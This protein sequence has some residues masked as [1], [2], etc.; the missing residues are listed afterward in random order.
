RILLLVNYDVDGVCA[1]K[2]LQTLFRC[3]NTLY[4]LVP[5]QGTQ[6]LVESYFKHVEQIKI[7]LMVNC[8]GNIDIVETLQPDEEIIFFIIDSHKPT[9]I[10]NIYSSEQVRLLGKPDREEWI[11]EF[12]DI[13]YD[14]GN[15]RKTKRRKLDEGAIMKQRERRM[16]KENRNRLMFEY[17]Q[18]SFYG[19]SSSMIIFDILWQLGKDS[20]DALWWAIVGVTYQIVF[21][22]I[23]EQRY[24][25]ELA[26]LQLHMSRL[27]TNEPGNEN[28]I[29]NATPTL[30]ITNNSLHLA[31]YRHWTVQSSLRNSLCTAIKLRL[32]TM[33][34]EKHLQQLL[35]EIGLPLSESKQRFCSMDIS[36]RQDFLSMMEK[37]AENYEIDDLIYT[38]FTLSYGYRSSYQASDYVYGL[39]ALMDVSSRN[40]QMG[41]CFSDALDSLARSKSD[42]LE[43]GIEGAKKILCC[44]FRHVQGLLDMKQIIATGPFLYFALQEG[45]L[46]VR[47]FAQAHFLTMLARCSLRAYH[48]VSR[49]KRSSCLPL[50]ASAPAYPENDAC[51]IIGIPPV[52]EVIPRKYVCA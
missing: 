41:S 19:R 23:D 51:I 12:S 35:A 52:S 6:D 42:L 37:A 28:G 38:S 24:S 43:V 46:D 49:S 25:N 48:S 44:I 1:C 34:G 7:I 21:G 5:V 13:F 15:D 2:I 4:T 27:L 31:L 8:G 10:C 30:K 29:R 39:L 45:S 9:D 36:L 33:R 32:W 47:M 26:V 22:L 40:K 14:E 11:P 16:W 17:T 50:V 20:A 18:F 3:D